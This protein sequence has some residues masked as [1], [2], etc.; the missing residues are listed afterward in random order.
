MLAECMYKALDRRTVLKWGNGLEICF[1]GLLSG[2]NIISERNLRYSSSME[3]K[4]R[5]TYFTCCEGL[6]AQPILQ[7]PNI[8]RHREKFLVTA[9]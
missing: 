8:R 6:H 7:E 4:S 5:E 1:C 2:I 9:S 3:S